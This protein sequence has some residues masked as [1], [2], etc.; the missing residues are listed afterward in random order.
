MFFFINNPYLLATET[1][2]LAT[3][4]PLPLNHW[5]VDFL[6]SLLSL[7]RRMRLQGAR[8]PRTAAKGFIYLA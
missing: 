1:T 8:T 5:Q 2:I 4:H 7:P 6:S 3:V